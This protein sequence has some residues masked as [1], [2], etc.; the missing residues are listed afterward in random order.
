M[1]TITTVPTVE[2]TINI[3]DNTFSFEVDTGA[4]DNFCSQQVWRKIG[5]PKLTTPVNAYEG[6]TGDT[7]PVLGTFE[8]VV[9]LPHQSNNE[10]TLRF[11]VVENLDLNLLGRDAILKLGIDVTSLINSKAGRNPNQVHA[12][13]SSLKA[14]EKLQTECKQLCSKFPELFKSELGCLKDFELEVEFKDD[15]KPK[16]CKPRVVPFAIQDDLT[17]AYDAGIKRGVWEPTNFSSYGTPVVP[18]RKR[19]LPGHTKGKLRVCGDYSVTVNSQLEDHRQPI[20]LPEDLMQKLGGGY[21]FTKIDL[22]DAYNQIMLAPES[23]KKLALSTHRGVLLQRRLPFGIKSAPGYFQQIMEQLTSDL[24]GV[25][26]YLDDIL[27]SGNDAQEHLQNLQ[28]LLQRLN[29]KGLRC[30]LEK[31]AFAQPVVEYLGHLMSHKGIAKGPKVDAV[32]NMPRP[33]DVSSLKSFLGSVQFYGKFLPN[34]STIAE[35]LYQLTRRNLPWKWGAEEESAFQR[36]K[37]MLCQDNVLVHFNPNQEIGISCDASEVGLGV[38]LFHRYADGCERPI[39][40][41][42]K[43]LTDTQRNYSQVQKEALAIIY[44]LHKFHQFLYGRRFILVTDHKPLTSLFGPNKATPK[45]AANRLARWALMLNQYNY[46]IEY[47]DTHDHGNADALSRLPAGP[48]EEFDGEESNADVDTICMI[49]T[50]SMQ[51]KPVDSTLLAKET[52]KDPVLA[53]V[54]RYIREGWPP[55]ISQDTNSIGYSLD[56]FRKLSSSLSTVH[57]CLLHGARIVIPASLHHQILQLLHTGHFGMQ[58]MKQL[59]RTA[60][61][62]PGIDKAIVDICHKCSTCAEHQNAPPKY[63]VHPWMVPENPWSRVHV[64]HAINFLGSNWLVMVDAYSKYP[65]IHATTSTSTKSTIDL[66][67]QDFAHFGYPHTIVSDNATTFKSDEFQAWC[68]ERGIIHLT[69]A[70]YHPATNGAAERLVQTFKQALKKS[71]L[72]PR[73]ALQEFLMQYRRTPLTIGY[74]PSELLNGRQIRTKI[75]TLLPSPVHEAQE[76]QARQVTKSQTVTKVEYVYQ[77]G[78]PCYALYCG[79]RRNKEP[80]WVAATVTKV[81]GSRNVN[82]RVYPKGPIWRRHVDQLRP[83]YGVEHDTEPG[84]DVDEVDV[85]DSGIPTIQEPRKQRQPRRNPRMPDGDEYGRHNLRRS[86]RHKR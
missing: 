38:V 29:E 14:D 34:L 12:V 17:K 37:N 21:G 4:G 78:S 60:V 46:K 54:M 26:V 83:R 81:Y 64:D 69:G 82:V 84:I 61:Y 53:L 79:P 85:K 70:P 9:T 7:L 75:D 56:D 41:A 15:A 77:V 18:I 33:E 23:Q 24:K 13:F 28:A 11:T 45:L 32:R 1:K 40:N 55:K 3:S 63:P 74:S 66:L 2:Q 39:A 86:Q 57:G 51:V 49:K 31:C 19:P 8:I 27:V 59:A 67:E 47:R 5:N 43:T 30:R 48:D 36:L 71:S 68:R 6:A 52:S 35:P 25:A 76:Q 16:F 20:P 73:A 10:K 42:S 50:I 58:R 44:A 72:P 65:C 22:A 80:R 62:W